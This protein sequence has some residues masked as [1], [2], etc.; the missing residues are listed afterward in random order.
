MEDQQEL[1]LTTT[2][3]L[4][5]ARVPDRAI[6]PDEPGRGKRRTRRGLAEHLGRLAMVWPAVLIFAA[7]SVTPLV[8]GI[9]LSMTNWD[10]VNAPGF[11]GL[12]NYGQ[13]LH[14]SDFRSALEFTLVVAVFGVLLQ[15]VLGLGLA[16]LLNRPVRFSKLYRAL[17]FYPV[18]LTAIAIGFLW[19]AL[20]D[21]Q[22][23]LNAVLT[24]TFHMQPLDMFGSPNSAIAAVVIVTVWQQV[25]FAMVLYLAGLQA[26]PRDL[27]AA[28]AVDG[29][30]SWQ[31]LRHITV[32]ML[33][34][35]I[36]IN[37]VLGLTGYLKL[38][39]L[40]IALTN[41]GPAGR[42]KTTVMRIFEDAFTNSR[43]GFAAAEGIVLAAITAALSLVI[44]AY[45]RRSEQ[46]LQ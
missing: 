18:V 35:T 11:L 37:V 44:I 40:V 24:S 30:S 12:R 42:T 19:H 28:A 46:G 21:Y 15:N 10:G 26:V 36:T 23:A 31:V 14:S 33:A 39:E 8:I 22:G 1:E 6:R 38:Y 34:P 13:V 20:L 7:F 43:P 2:L 25:G 16:L 41:G 5:A 9:Y 3:P 17:F 45:R 32:P 29:A 27:G 4:A